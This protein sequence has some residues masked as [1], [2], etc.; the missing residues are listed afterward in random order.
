MDYLD[1]HAKVDA[2]RHD[3][4]S[5]V[6]RVPRASATA[7]VIGLVPVA[8]LVVEILVEVRR[9]T[10]GPRPC[11]AH[12][13]PSAKALAAYAGLVPTV[14]QNGGAARYGDHETG[15]PVRRAMLVQ[16]SQTLLNR[17]GG[18]EAEPLQAIGT[19]ICTRR[20]RRKIA[21]VGAPQWLATRAPAMMRR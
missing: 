13:F 12:R 17:C 20:G 15:I 21:G 1:Q 19:R 14:D 11:D 18:A 4:W 10:Q 2:R 16:A 7:T 5:I 9:R 8:I 6:Q 3:G